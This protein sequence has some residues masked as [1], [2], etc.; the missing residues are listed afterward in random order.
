MGNP[1]SFGRIPASKK[2]REDALGRKYESVRQPI[3]GEEKLTPLGNQMKIL[4][5]Y[6]ESMNCSAY[7]NAWCTTTSSGS[8]IHIRTDTPAASRARMERKY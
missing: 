5:S 3:E 7:K 4:R 8:L 2:V 6:E 1:V